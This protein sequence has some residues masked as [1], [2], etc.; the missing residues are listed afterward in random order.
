[1]S[2]ASCHERRMTHSISNNISNSIWSA[3]ETQMKPLS[4]LIDIHPV[5]WHIVQSHDIFVYYC[6]CEQLARESLSHI[7]P[8][9]RTDASP[10]SGRYEELHKLKDIYT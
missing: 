10:F 3:Y 6:Y 1:M 8:S 7:E 9:P 5:N 2:R 4:L